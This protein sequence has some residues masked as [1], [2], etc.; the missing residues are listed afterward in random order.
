ML[1]P[2]L[3]ASLSSLDTEWE[4]NTQ[5]DFVTT[6]HP[7]ILN[8]G[9]KAKQREKEREKIGSE[10]DFLQNYTNCRKDGLWILVSGGKKSAIMN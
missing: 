1:L 4:R 2:F 9:D 3:H 8:P 5:H 6:S 10:R 7:W